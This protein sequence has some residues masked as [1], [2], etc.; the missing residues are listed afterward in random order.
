MIEDGNEEVYITRTD[1]QMTYEIE[2]ID[3]S[4]SYDEKNDEEVNR[5]SEESKEDEGVQ[6]DKRERTREQ[7]EKGEEDTRKTKRP[8][9][10]PSRA[11]S[12]SS[13]R[14]LNLL[15]LGSRQQARAKKAAKRIPPAGRLTTDKA[16]W[17]EVFEVLEGLLRDR[18]AV[19]THAHRVFLN[20]LV[21]NGSG[22]HGD[23]QSPVSYKLLQEI[24]PDGEAPTVYQP[25]VD[26]GLVIRTPHNRREGRSAEY[27]LSP[28]VARQVE[29]RMP[30]TAHEATIAQR[31]NLV[32]GKRT[33]AVAK[34]LTSKQPPI[35]AAAMRALERG[36]FNDGAVRAHLR[37]LH[38]RAP[39]AQAEWEAAGRPDRPH[40]AAV[41][42]D[43]TQGRY[44]NDRRA[45]DAVLRQDVRATD[46]PD[47]WSYRLAYSVA[48]TGRLFQKGRG[49]QGASQ[50]MKAA[51]YSGIGDVRNYDLRACHPNLLVGVL[52]GL[53]ID[54]SWFGAFAADPAVRRAWAVD[55][56]LPEG[57]FKKV[58]LALVNGASF[59]STIDRS[60]GVLGEQV[61]SHV[62]PDDHDRVWSALR[63]VVR[64]GLESLR[65][66][67]RYLEDGYVRDHGANGRSGRS[68]AN[69]VGVRL[70]EAE[71]PE[72]ERV[73]RLAPFIL[74]GL[75]SA[76]VHRL[77]TLGA[78]FGYRPISHE[79]D[80]LVV[81]GEVPD[82]ALERA[83]AEARV[84]RAVLVEKPLCSGED[85]SRL[86]RLGVAV[87][88]W[89]RRS[90]GCS[91]ASKGGRN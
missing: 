11:V 8:L 60:R 22:L 66:W 10:P 58:V 21:Q 50:A 87:G 13:I 2:S 91:N 20:H 38:S 40:P 18:V 46:E 76:V 81:V 64:P 29:A 49:L 45:Y 19:P 75:E 15:K 27:A 61:R 78:E 5:E 16:V 52:E 7:E 48:S 68:V 32:T 85:V 89:P 79:H 80:G 88:P 1:E 59:P 31:R 67:H 42:R 69:A 23:G 37:G 39:L 71:I 65:E 28:E 62:A 74:Q 51:A 77:A 25:L 82:R 47:V 12:T 54:G 63:D 4:S 36:A 24:S 35:I 34:S 86:K 14:T 33:V 17:S 83:K 84:A 72:G 56:G 53:G 90:G 6:G 3:R 43:Q 73:R 41:E 55:A 9:D 26:A 57:A 44:E 70:L 30:A